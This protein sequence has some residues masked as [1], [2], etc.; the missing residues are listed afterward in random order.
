[1]ALVLGA[2]VVL[3]R[4]ERC[5]VAA[6][7]GRRLFAWPI[8]AGEAFEVTFTHSLNLSPITDVIEWS[9]DD[10][11][12][13]K[14]VFRTFGAGVPV[15]A[16]GVGEELLFIDGHYELTGINKHMSG[17]TIMTQEVPNHIITFKD[18]EA[19]LL[20]LVGS[21]KAVDIAVRRVPS[22]LLFLDGRIQSDVR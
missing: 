7:G 15:P 17:F 8:A 11:I 10:L 4:P 2:A 6:C 18:R 21:G 16:D 1:M 5:L 12:V 14:S 3:L 13:R 19:R 9:G 20:D 22:F